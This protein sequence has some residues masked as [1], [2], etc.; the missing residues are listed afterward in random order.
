[1]LSADCYPSALLQLNQNQPRHFFQR[2]K[3][4]F[5]L[6]GH[7]FKGRL[8]FLRQFALQVFHGHGAGQV[9]LIELQDVR[10]LLEV[11]TV[12]FQ[13]FL[14]VF[15][16]FNVGVEA[17]FL[18]IGHKDHAIHAAQDQ[19]SAGIVKDLAGNGIE[20]ESGAKAADSSQIEREEVKEECPVR[21][22]GQGDH[23]ALLFVDRFI[24][25]MLQVRGLTAQTG[26]VI[27]DLAVNFA[28]GK[29]N[30]AQESPHT[31]G[32]K[33]VRLRFRTAMKL[34]GFFIS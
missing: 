5:S 12:F 28:G 31:R 15:Q 14:Q 21:F 17:L 27:D 7:S 23:L 13:V 33:N 26:A 32:A 18:R 9:T 20:M 3:D 16:R 19:L 25:N 30:K 1:M 29:V 24:E 8:V 6:K 10:D 22:R 2:F 34:K 4:A 11:V